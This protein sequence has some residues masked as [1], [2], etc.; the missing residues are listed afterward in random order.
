MNKLSSRERM[1]K[2]I[3]YQEVDHIPCSFMS[4]TALRNK[5]GDNFYKLCEAELDLGLDSMLFLPYSS[6]KERPD[7][8][9]LRGL[10]VQLPT[11]VETKEWRENID[12]DFDVLHKE[13]ITPVGNLTTSVKLSGDWPHGNHIPFVDDFQVPRSI[14]PLITEQKD[15][16]VLQYILQPP[17]DEV[18]SNFSKEAEKAQSFINEKNVLLV[19]GWG[20][21]MDMANWFCGMQNLMTLAISNVSFVEDLFDIIHK[22]NLER[23]EVVLSGNIDLYIRRSW[24]EGCD[25]VLPSFYEDVILPRLIKEIAL[26]H[27]HDTKFGYICSSGLNPMLELHKQAGFDVL[28]GIDPI[29]GTR[30][31][32]PK[33]KEEYSGQIATW[34]GVSGAITVEMG[35]ESEIREAVDQAIELL[36]PDG[37]ILSPVDNITVDEPKTWKNIDTF[38]DMWKRHW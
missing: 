12:N 24:Y 21:G 14:K 23:M 9:E 26:A 17:T 16:D 22:W 29:Q 30:T 8:P 18:I 1:L 19:G 20:V 34:G 10:P 3:N 35:T 33:I 7:H 27:D 4:F 31:D 25:F 6:R 37:F 28:I 38:I 2:T 11:D 36:G 13:Y 32:M 15:L 5:V